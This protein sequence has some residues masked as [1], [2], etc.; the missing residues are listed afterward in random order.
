[1]GSHCTVTRSEKAAS[2][3]AAASDGAVGEARPGAKN[4]PRGDSC[5]PGGLPTDGP[6]S[7]ER[8]TRAGGGSMART[9][10]SHG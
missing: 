4:S 1:M 6:A 5:A 10:P 8:G 3:A 7:G 2:G 9:S